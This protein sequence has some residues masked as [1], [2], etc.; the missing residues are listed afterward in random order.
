MVFHIPGEGQEFWLVRKVEEVSSQQHL[1]ELI[2]HYWVDAAN[3]SDP[4]V[5]DPMLRANNI[6]S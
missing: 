4:L 5:W 1:Y 2:A 6:W 3:V